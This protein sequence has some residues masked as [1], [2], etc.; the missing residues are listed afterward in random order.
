VPRWITIAA[1]LGFQALRL[2][3]LAQLHVADSVDAAKAA[4]LLEQCAAVVKA[5][6]SRYQRH[7]DL[8]SAAAL[9]EGACVALEAYLPPSHPALRLLTRIA[10]N[11]FDALDVGDK[12]RVCGLPPHT[13]YASRC[14]S[15]CRSV[16]HS[17]T[18]AL[19]VSCTCVCLALS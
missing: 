2:C 4:E 9:A 19:L 3:R 14:A 15:S 16:L 5:V 13:Q 11:T 17:R 6:I 10:E 12:D 1:A 18:E 8:P 7:G